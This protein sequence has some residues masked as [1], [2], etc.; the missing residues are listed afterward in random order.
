[1]PSLT[2]PSSYKKRATTL[3]RKAAPPPPVKAATSSRTKK[4]KESEPSNSEIIVLEK[5]HSSPSHRYSIDRKTSPGSSYKPLKRE[6]LYAASPGESYVA[7]VD[8]KPKQEG[9]LSLTKGDNVE[10]LYIGKGGFMEGIVGQ[11]QGWFPQNAIKRKSKAD[12]SQIESHV[13]VNSE[14]PPSSEPQPSSDL[15]TNH[16]SNESGIRTLVIHRGEK[17]FGFAMRGIKGNVSAQY[18]H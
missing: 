17:S 10:V 4:E 16:I 9:D 14:L 6:R 7:T 8:V 13:D 3:P 18:L 1:V 12:E 5:N 2:Q 11:N 15:E